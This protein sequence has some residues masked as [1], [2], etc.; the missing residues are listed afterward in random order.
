MPEWKAE[1]LRRLAPL[2]LAPTREAEIADELSQHLDDRY[3]ELVASSQSEDAALRTAL[4]ELKGEDLLVRS[5]RRV[6]RDLYREPIAP[7]KDSG[8]FFSGVFQDIR[9]A[10]RTLRKFPGFSA[11]VVLTLALGIGAN[12]AIFSILNSLLLNNLPVKDPQQLVFLTNPD[13]AGG[14]GI[15][16]EDGA[17]DLVTYPE[18]QEI[19]RGNQVFSGVLAVSS[20]T[21]RVPVEVEGPNSGNS[22]ALS[23][24][25]LVSGS[26]F[27]VLGVNPILG[28]AFGPEVDNVRDANP[29]A[30]ISYAFWQ[31]RFGGAG[32]VLGRK[33][34]I[35]RTTYDVIGVAPPRFHGETVGV[36]PVAWVPL[37]MQSEIVPGVDYLTPETN[38][39]LKT[40]WIQ[41]IGRLKPGVTFAHAKAAIDV[42]FQQMM[43]AETAGMSAHD[44]QQY[45]TQRLVVTEGSH[46]ASTLRED[47]AKPLQILM[48]VV[49]LILLIACANVANILLARSAARQKE[50][51][52]RVAL[53]AGAPRLFRQVLTESILLAGIGGVV[54]LLLAHWADVAL[55][56]MVSSGATQVPLDICLSAKILAFT[57]GVSLLTGILFG[58]A[59]AF[60]STRVDLESV[61]KGASR[62]VAGGGSRRGRVPIAKVLVVAQVALS[63][64]LLVVAGLF[65]RSFRN[66]AEVQLG[67]N[68]D[69]ILQFRAS[70][71]TYGYQ[72]PEILPLYQQ[73][74]DRIA[75][76]PGVRGATLS[77]NGLL[78][79]TDST[80]SFTIE[81]QRT[82]A[83]DDE[84]THWDLVGP[85]FFSTA[86]IPI[87]M[88]R[89]ITSQDSGNGQRVGVINQTLARKYFA[90][91]NPIGKRIVMPAEHFDFVI[92]GVAADSKHNSVRE[93]PFPRFYIPYFN[94]AGTDWP[95]AVTFVIRTAG[96]PSAV[97]SAIRAAVKQ[98]AAN[99]PPL[100][101]QTMDQRLAASLSSDS[102]ITELAGAFGALAIVL[103]CI[104]LYGI[105]AYAVSGR[106]NE[107]GIRIALGAQRGAILWMILRESLLLVL[108]GVAIGLPAVYG[109]GQWVSSSLFGV[110]PADPL[111]IALATALMS[112][113]GIFACYIPARRA[114]RV[115]PMVA[116]RYE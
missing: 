34:R 80:D 65:I 5:L 49:G 70:A 33:I 106:V 44:K 75:A 56:R 83:S 1:I 86:G 91:S 81:G 113:V 26:Y 9:Y 66:L 17:R 99:L 40:E 89:E 27:S 116:L 53:G 15:G 32:D 35:L 74:L 6:E 3:R 31:A 79:G 47:F 114:M 71:L 45:L 94:P 55:L 2:K 69:H 107:I 11:V 88:G 90:N 18:F 19:A 39:F 22:V 68:R 20:Y 48:A 51:A 82:K 54:G 36:D 76:V 87:L 59:P 102:M 104:G 96:D 28:R 29:V 12:T 8:N 115:D 105:M 16:F 61:L 101:L 38:H 72:R 10:L 52:V 46:G 98:T 100:Q 58:I 112:L 84:E 95:T 25:S 109:A 7:G 42:E 97:T 37:T 21:P 78:G 64:L 57:F 103:V 108:I 93:K 73:M 41:V 77:D 62:N 4:D 50:I 24:V 111:A 63:L 60:R 92:V 85:N 67:F 110:Q 30:V 13:A 14:S 43:Q 23:R